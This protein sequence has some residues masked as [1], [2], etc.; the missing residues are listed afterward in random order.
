MRCSTPLC[1]R[2]VIK[3]IYSSKL[4]VLQQ[5]KKAAGNLTAFVGF[6]QSG[7]LPNLSVSE[8]CSYAQEIDATG[9]YSITDA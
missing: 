2:A 3:A 9:L 6:Y 7:V 4:K 5:N 8:T 1:V